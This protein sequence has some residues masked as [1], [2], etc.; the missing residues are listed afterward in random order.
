MSLR[1]ILFAFSIS[2]LLIGCKKKDPE[3]TTQSSEFSFTGKINGSQTNYFSGISNYYMFSNYATDANNIREFVSELKTKN[4]SG[5][6]GGSLK[7]RIKDYRDL[8]SMTT[9]I[10]SSIHTSYYPYAT[11]AG[12]AESFNV[13]MSPTFAGGTAQSYTWTYFDASISNLATPSKVY[14]TGKY[15][16]CCDIQSATSCVSS[17]CNYI[18]VGQ[19]ENN[20][21]SWFSASA[22]VGNQISFTSS[23]VLG[24]PPYTYY[25]NF[26]DGNTSTLANPSHTY[27]T[28]GVYL[29]SLTVTD[30]K[31]IT[32]T[33]SNNVN[34]TAPGTCMTRF[35]YSKTPIANP[36]NLGNIII[37]W[38]DASGVVYT[39]DD[40][41]QASNSVFKVISVE[42]YKTNEL[43]QRTKKIKASLNCTLFNGASSILVQ[44]AELV[45]AI[46]YP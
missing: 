7:L 17:L 3:M 20:V 14:K 1:N 19:T 6:C 13:T 37:E 43:G 33:L 42:E 26:G 29:V 23:P 46:A 28:N 9:L 36:T 16:I 30:S 12:T 10:D 8:I 40:N 18:N 34:T 35:S 27:A 39:S 15:N 32:A 41:T 25:W 11:P 5:N 38:T 21:E 44:D 2:L 31:N 45:F 4:C 24:F 22:P